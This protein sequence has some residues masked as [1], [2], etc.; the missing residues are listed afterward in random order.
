MFL[1]LFV[2]AASF[3]NLAT[4]M[5]RLTHCSRHCLCSCFWACACAHVSGLVFVLMFL[6]LVFVHVSG[7]CFCLAECVWSCPTNAHA[8]FVQWNWVGLQSFCTGRVGNCWC[9]LGATP[10]TNTLCGYH[11]LGMSISTIICSTSCGVRQIALNIAERE[12]PQTRP[13]TLTEQMHLFKG[14]WIWSTA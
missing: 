13:G 14:V 10:W 6:G 1:G 11:V 2:L 3:L 4:A 12:R 7:P 5:S 9:W 8:Q